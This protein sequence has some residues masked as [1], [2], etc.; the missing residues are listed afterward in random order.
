M[1]LARSRPRRLRL[2]KNRKP[3]L[4]RLIHSTCSRVTWSGRGAKNR[5][6]DGNSLR[7]RKAPIVR[8]GRT[9]GLCFP[10]RAIWAVSGWLIRLLPGNANLDWRTK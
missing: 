1:A 6:R 8:R 5:A 7:L 9:P 4:K 3:T 2:N 10:V